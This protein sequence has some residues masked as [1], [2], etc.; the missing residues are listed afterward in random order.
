[1]GER[2]SKPLGFDLFKHPVYPDGLKEDFVAR[3]ELNSA[4][5]VIL[6][7][8]HMTATFMLSDISLEYDAQFDESYAIIVGDLCW[9]NINL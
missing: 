6:F 1:M 3:R 8:R 7:S 2:F 9:T 4:G 5:K